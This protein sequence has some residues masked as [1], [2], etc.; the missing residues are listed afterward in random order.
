MGYET[1][2]RGNARPSR[3]FYYIVLACGLAAC[4]AWLLIIDT[5]PYSDFEYYHNLA[6][7]IAGGGQWGD[8]YTS[9]GYPIALGAAYKL[10]GASLTVAKGFNLLFYLVNAALAFS[11]L[12]RVSMRENARKAAFALFVLF[13]ASIYYTSVLGTEILFTTMLLAIIRVYLGQARWKYFWIGALTALAA[14]IKPFFLAFFLV[15]FVADIAAF[16]TR[17]LAAAR[18]SAF[19]LVVSLA[20]LFPWL[21]RNTSLMGQP[22]FISNNGG[23]VLYVNNNSSNT[24]GRWMPADKVEDPVV[25]TPEYL[26]ANETKKNN[27]LSAAARDW[28][29][30]HPARFAE[31]G[32]LRL[33][34]T[35]IASGDLDYSLY[36]AEVSKDAISRLALAIDAVRLPVFILGYLS[37]LA[38]AV[39]AVARLIRGPRGQEGAPLLFLATFLMFAGIYFVTEGQARYSYP[40]LFITTFFCVHGLT[41]VLE[42]ASVRLPLGHGHAGRRMAA[43]K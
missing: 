20:V 32:L 24:D 35:Y 21:Y 17:P 6:I 14:M 10:F 42:R 28:I 41:V 33:D 40:T 25:L 30:S 5:Q 39:A 13:P 3:R 2:Q 26:E 37:M 19:V 4:L 11:I 8:T 27:M 9:V 31:L 18:N 34:Q 38:Y 22:T 15:V 29:I 12:L 1:Q 23:I 16:K 7:Q 36:G 43:M